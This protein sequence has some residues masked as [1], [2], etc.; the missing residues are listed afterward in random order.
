MQHGQSETRSALY[1][2]AVR[3]EKMHKH[4]EKDNL[5]ACIHTDVSCIR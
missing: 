3:K 4:A 5:A 1:Y 2:S